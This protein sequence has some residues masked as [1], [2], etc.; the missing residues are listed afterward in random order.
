MSDGVTESELPNA[1]GRHSLCLTS[2]SH[3]SLHFSPFSHSFQTEPQQRVSQ[4]WATATDHYTSVMCSLCMYCIE[5]RRK[6]HT[7]V[8]RVDL[9]CPHTPRHRAIIAVPLFLI[10]PATKWELCLLWTSGKVDYS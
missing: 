8:S 7:V 5:H 6:A 3:F 2:R 10:C 9:R 1:I 4:Q